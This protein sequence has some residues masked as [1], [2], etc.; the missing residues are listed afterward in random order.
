MLYITRTS[1]AE[2]TGYQILST[3]LFFPV[4]SFIHDEFP[5]A[6][7]LEFRSKQP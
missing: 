1:L 4:G 6:T 5:S 7:V 2:S 3:D